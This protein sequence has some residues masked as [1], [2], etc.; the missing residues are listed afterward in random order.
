VHEVGPGGFGHAGVAVAVE[1]V[2]LEHRRH[3]TRS[4]QRAEEELANARAVVRVYEVEGWRVQQ[5]LDW[6]AEGALG[7][8]TRELQRAV[9]VE[10]GDDVVRVPDERLDASLALA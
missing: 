2:E 7:R 10:H 6:A 8:R 4:G 1:H 3:G 5:V 9:A